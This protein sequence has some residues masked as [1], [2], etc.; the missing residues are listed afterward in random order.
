MRIRKHLDQ[1][2]CEKRVHAFITSKLD[3]CNTILNGLPA[4]ELDK[5]QL[6]QNAA[7]RLVTRIGG[8]RCI[9]NNEF[10]A[11]NLTWNNELLCEI[12]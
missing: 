8:L 3:S 7:A 10:N 6:V 1:A 9:M 5:L 12:L 4:V 2:D 11:P